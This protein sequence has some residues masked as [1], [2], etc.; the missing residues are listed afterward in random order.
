MLDA[1][2]AVINNAARPRFEVA[3]LAIEVEVDG[4]AIRHQ[5]PWPSKV[6]SSPLP[7]PCWLH[8]LMCW[9]CTGTYL[10]S[11]PMVQ[12]KKLVKRRHLSSIYNGTRMGMYLIGPVV[13]P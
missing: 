4:L 11:L 3:S 5:Y 12:F 9:E 13:D 6:S 8:S 1:S 7:S 2:S 10:P